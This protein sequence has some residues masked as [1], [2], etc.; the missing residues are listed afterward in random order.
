MNE[1]FNGQ[2]Q[3]RSCPLPCLITS[4][5]LQVI[6][7]TLARKMVIDPQMSG[8]LHGDFAL[9]IKQ[10]KRTSRK[11]MYNCMYLVVHPT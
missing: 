8:Y 9:A 6:V 11:T 10:V 1:G 3:M 5:Y 7:A 2:S 4:G